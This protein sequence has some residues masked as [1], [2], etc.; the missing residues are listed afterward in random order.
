MSKH[1]PGPWVTFNYGGNTGDGDFEGFGVCQQGK[2]VAVMMGDPN[3]YVC[4]L[5]ESKYQQANGRL[6]AAA[7]DMLRALK[8][9]ECALTSLLDR[10][11]TEAPERTDADPDLFLIRTTIDKALGVK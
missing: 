4:D 10:Q 7:P 2:S 9:A 8:R 5:P 6:I 11:N 3:G 1:T